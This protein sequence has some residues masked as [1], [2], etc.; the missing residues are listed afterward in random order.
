MMKL[1]DDV[2]DGL[3]HAGKFGEPPLLDHP[4]EGFGK[5]GETIGCARVGL[6]M[7]Y[8]RVARSAA[9]ILSTGWRRFSHP[10]WARR[11]SQPLRSARLIFAADA[12]EF[13]LGR[14]LL[15]LHEFSGALIALGPGAFAHRLAAKLGA[16]PD[17]ALP[18]II[19]SGFIGRHE[20]SLSLTLFSKST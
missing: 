14:R 15:L 13:L 4:L 6:G 16:L 1:G 7:D 12:L 18:G 2:R 17:G 11:L 10:P 5:S 20:E 9:R 19:T 8:R 3:S